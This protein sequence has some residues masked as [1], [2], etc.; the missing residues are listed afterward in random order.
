MMA[1]SWGFDGSQYYPPHMSAWSKIQLGWV[2]PTVITAA[3]TYT[4]RKACEFP[5]LFQISKNFPS[6]EYLLIENRQKCKFDGVI[7]GPG[8]AV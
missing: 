4:A 3:G 1:N 8:L 6:G 2:K 7:S 5:D